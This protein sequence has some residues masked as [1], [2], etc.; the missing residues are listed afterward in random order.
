MILSLFDTIS[1]DALWLMI[2][3]IKV[4]LFNANNALMF[5]MLIL[6]VL[7]HMNKGK[8]ETKEKEQDPTDNPEK[9]GD[10]YKADSLEHTLVY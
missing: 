3:S 2:V 1:A 9:A 7:L 5:L 6:M 10:L 4:T 8:S